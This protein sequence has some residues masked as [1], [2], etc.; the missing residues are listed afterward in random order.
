MNEG[1]L[2]PETVLCSL[3]CLNLL[4]FILTLLGFSRCL[5]EHLLC[6]GCFYI[7]TGGAYGRSVMGRYCLHIACFSAERA[8][9]PRLPVQGPASSCSSLAR[10]SS[11]V[12]YGNSRVF[13][14][15]EISTPCPPHHHFLPCKMAQAASCGA[16]TVH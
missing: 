7:L 15:V 16:L 4:V 8:S 10:P 11:H 1:G 12:Q 6:A 9:S 14:F 3:Y 5:F 13:A 2:P